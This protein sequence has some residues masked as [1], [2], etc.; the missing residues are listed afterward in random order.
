MLEGQLGGRGGDFVEPYVIAH[1]FGHHIQNLLGT[2][3]RVRTQ[4]GPTSDSVRLE[5]QADCYAGMW[6]RG[7]TGTTDSKGVQIFE[8]IDEDDITEALDAAKS[9]GDDCI[10]KT[11]RRRRQPGAVDARLLRGSGCDG[12]PPATTPPTSS[13]ATRSRPTTSE[14]AQADQRLDLRELPLERPQ[15]R[16]DRGVPVLPGQRALAAGD[17]ASAHSARL[18]AVSTAATRAPWAA[19]SRVASPAGSP[20]R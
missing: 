10:Q 5:L 2:M 4:Q 16:R 15:V 11:R 19:S 8:A 18:S 6:T 14:R 9:V 17:P 12:S 7:A 3:S 1:E 20:S 13:S